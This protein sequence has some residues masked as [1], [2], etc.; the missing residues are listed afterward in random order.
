MRT[1]PAVNEWVERS[2]NFAKEGIKDVEAAFADLDAHL[3][4]RSYIVGYGLSKADIAVYKKINSNIKA[5]SFHKQGVFRNASRWHNF[6]EENNPDLKASVMTIRTKAPTAVA[7]DNFE[8]GLQGTEKG[9]V[10][11]FPPEP[12]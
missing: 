3:T 1:S 10:T 7:G 5:K 12:S 11:R 2:D 6:I 8:I 4:L 9:V